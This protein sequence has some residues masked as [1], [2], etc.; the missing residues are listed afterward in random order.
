[1]GL[2][3]P[4]CRG[5]RPCCMAYLVV[6]GD[7]YPGQPRSGR[8]VAEPCQTVPV[9]I[10]TSL[11]MILLYIDPGA[12]TMVIQAALAALIAVPFFFRTQVTRALQRLREL[13]GRDN[14]E[15]PT[16]A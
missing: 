1:M 10:H 11:R 16:E 15:P 5:R 2:P 4:T 12:G 13:R 6:D 7:H 8:I 9:F 14:D 3:L